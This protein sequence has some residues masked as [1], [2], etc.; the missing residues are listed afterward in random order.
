MWSRRPRWSALLGIL[1]MIGLLWALTALNTGLPTGALFLVMWTLGAIVLFAI[2][3]AI[4][5]RSTRE[6]VR[7][8]L[9]S[10]RPRDA[11]W[12]A[13]VCVLRPLWTNQQN[14]W[15]DT[16]TWLRVFGDAADPR[17][18]VK[19]SSE[20]PRMAMPD[21]VLEEVDLYSE[22]ALSRRGKEVALMHL[23]ILLLP[24]CMMLL[25]WLAGGSSA[26]IKYV[27]PFFALYIIP[28]S[29]QLARLGIAPFY[30]QSA[31]ASPGRVSFSRMRG[32]PLAFERRDSVLLIYSHMRMTFALFCRVD[33][34]VAVLQFHSGLKDPGLVQLLSRWCLPDWRL[35]AQ[36]EFEQ[37]VQQ[38]IITDADLVAT[39]S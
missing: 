26:S 20:L 17:I 14:R 29:A 2:V 37:P 19:Q 27:L 11:G 30:I 13:Q 36:R 18:V 9:R 5:G 34:R 10:R 6:K 12:F 1:A 38:R 7:G 8:V 21:D 3:I 22:R 35:R 39:P 15:F 33:G 16:E 28:I 24:L 23:T 25:P 4:V 31:V 32:E